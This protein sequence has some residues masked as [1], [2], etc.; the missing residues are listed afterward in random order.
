MTLTHVLVLG[1]VFFA[2]AGFCSALGG[3]LLG[4]PLSAR[5]RQA[6]AGEPL[7]DGAPQ[8][9]WQAKVMAALQPASQ[10]ALPQEGW[11]NSPVRRGFMH[12][13]WRNEHAVVLFFACKTLL[14][15]VLPALLVGAHA[16][17]GGG[18]AADRL[19][20]CVVFLAALG[21]YAPNIYLSRRV[22]AR[23]REIFEGLPDAIDLMTVM[24]EAGLGLDAAIARIAEEM[25]A[26][27][28]AV[29]EEFKLV[30]L[31]LRAGASRNQAL[32]N[33][34]LR[35]GVEEVEFFVAMLVQTDRFGTSMADSLRVHSETLRGRRMQRAEEQAAKIG[36]KLLFPLVFCIFPAIMVVLIGPAAISIY[37]NFFPIAARFGGS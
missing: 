36:L 2:T 9:E 15:F 21:Y 8:G 4:N 37:R 22:S 34:A 31:E 26:R 7:G 5:L 6:G 29:G 12:A 33:L 1:L 11:Q 27:S 23:Q 17:G 20:V 13:G 30:G 3:L 24:V 16:F 10:L 25:G 14:S 35:T 19:V 32:R 28:R 18:M